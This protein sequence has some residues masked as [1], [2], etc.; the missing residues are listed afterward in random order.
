M[1]LLQPKSLSTILVFTLFILPHT[2]FSIIPSSINSIFLIVIAIF[3][4]IFISYNFKKITNKI[5]LLPFILTISQVIFGILN[6]IIHQSFSYFNLLSPIVCYVGFIYLLEYK[7]NLKLFLYIFPILYC[8]YYFVYFSVLPDLFFRPG[9]D[10][11]AIVFDNS[12]SNAI[13]ITLNITLYFFIIFNQYYRAKFQLYILFFAIIN[14]TLIIIQQSR[15]GLL[16]SILVLLLSFYQFNKKV[17]Y[18]FGTFLIGSIILIIFFNIGGI[19]DF[20]EVLGSL[21]GITALKEDTRGIAQSEFFNK[22]T[23]FNTFFGYPPN[24]IYVSAIDGEIKYTYNVFL[25]VWNRYT[26]VNFLFFILVI[27]YRFFSFKKYE[28]SLVYFIPFFAYSMIE[29]L[30]F[31]NFWDAIIFLLFFLTRKQANIIRKVY[32]NDNYFNENLCIQ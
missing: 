31:P 32:S 4:L 8:F 23:Y 19:T 28:F 30:F 26:I 2:I 16:C 7:I 24:T 10:E 20:L 18:Y 5:I 1:R 22:L 15:G 9:F 29:S 13:P 27:I 11:D 17:F 3:Y 25:D 12:S 6:I 21:D 14:F